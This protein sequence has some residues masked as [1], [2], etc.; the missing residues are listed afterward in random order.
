MPTDE[1]QRR[2]RS[3]PVKKGSTGPARRRPEDAE[4]EVAPPSPGELDARQE[5]INSTRRKGPEIPPGE[6]GALADIE[7]PEVPPTECDEPE[8]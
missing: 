6:S 3:F 7:R 1:R 8:G 4:A 2:E 5:R